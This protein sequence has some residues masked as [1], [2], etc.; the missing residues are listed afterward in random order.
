[1]TQRQAAVRIGLRRALIVLVHLGLW[2]AAYFLAFGL[3]FDFDANHRY[4]STMLQWYPILLG[5]RFAISWFAGSFRGM[6]KYTGTR[7]LKVLIVTTTLSSAAFVAVL[8]LLFRTLPRSVLVIEWALCIILVG[9]ARF[10]YRAWSA[11]R[12]PPPRPDVKPAR[13]LIVGAGDAGEL[14]LREVLRNHA[15]RYRVIGLV[16]DKPQKVGE[17]I[18]GVKVLGSVEQLPALVAAHE[19]EEVVIA[20]PSATGPQ[21]R[22]LVERCQASGARFRTIPGVDQLIDGRVTLSQIRAVD[23][24]DLLGREPVTLDTEAI[25]GDAEPRGHGD[26]RRRLHRLGAV[27]PDLP[28]RPLGAAPGRADRERPLRD[29]P[30]AGGALPRAAGDPL[31]GRHLRP[32]ADGGALRGP[33]AH[34]GLPRRRPQARADDG[35]EPR[36]GDQEQRPRHAAAGR[37]GRRPRRAP[38]SS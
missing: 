5:I 4:A 22:R 29:R 28:L 7:D 20:V 16:D 33:P 26:R 8:G 31:R 3:R 21:M 6:W 10:A 38:R 35:V 24:E 18:H 27:P 19:V 13:M 15:A 25:S 36:R 11:D 12:R 2:T 14:L 30:R 9:G 37:P 34:R 23:I 1:M 32:L 17:Y